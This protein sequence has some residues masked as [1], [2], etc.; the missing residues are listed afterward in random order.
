MGVVVLGFLSAFRPNKQLTHNLIIARGDYDIQ[1]FK[2]LFFYSQRS[3]LAPFCIVALL[4]KPK[5]KK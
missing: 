3:S 1:T 2:L 5:T 4:T